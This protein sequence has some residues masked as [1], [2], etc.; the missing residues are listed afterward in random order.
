MLKSRPPHGLLWR[1][2]LQSRLLPRLLPR[3]L[4]V[5][6]MLPRRLLLPRLLMS[7]R[8][9]PPPRPLPRL[10]L[11]PSLLLLLLLAPSL[12][13]RM[14]LLLLGKPPFPSFVEIR[15]AHWPSSGRV[16][17][18]LRY[19]M[20]HPGFTSPSTALIIL[21]SQTSGWRMMTS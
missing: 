8:M 4:S 19:M 20:S 17:M 2:M 5:L 10:L 7:K 12:L 3:R 16:M 15:S 6:P 11:A 9:P 18:P 14:L 21:L 13:R 1:L